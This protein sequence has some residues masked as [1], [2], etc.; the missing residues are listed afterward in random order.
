M[1]DIIINDDSEEPDGTDEPPEKISYNLS[2][3]AE[4]EEIT[5]SSPAFSYM[6]PKIQLRKLPYGIGMF[7]NAPILKDEVVIGWSGRVVH[8]SEV[9]QMKPEDRHY[10]LQIDDE[11]FQ[12]P[13]WPGYN[14]PADFTNHSCDP[15]CGFGNSAVTLV[16]MRDIF[17]GEELTFDYAMA[18]SIESL[19]GNWDCLCGASQ[20]RK[21]IRGSDWKLPELWESYQ[22]G[23]YFSPYLRRKIE[24]LQQ[25]QGPLKM[26]RN[27]RQ[28]RRVRSIS[29]SK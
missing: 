24:R 5:F 1:C 18:D 7:A 23:T 8:L 28:T 22:S 6:S 20:C 12:A 17:L 29:V 14:E 11:L 26:D 13:F 9:L 25:L 21:R 3:P 19:E 2:S 4:I 27:L 10:V 16:A 15:N